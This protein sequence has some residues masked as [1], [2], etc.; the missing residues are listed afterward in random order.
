MDKIVFRGLQQSLVTHRFSLRLRE[1]RTLL[2][3]EALNGGMQGN[4]IPLVLMVNRV[5]AAGPVCAAASVSVCGSVSVC[6]CV[7]LWT[8]LLSAG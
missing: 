7:E 1:M 6:V 3:I 5:T 2:L 8:D 4:C